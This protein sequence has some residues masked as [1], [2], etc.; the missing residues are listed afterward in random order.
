MRLAVVERVLR[1]DGL[2]AEHHAAVLMAQEMAVEHVAAGEL[3]EAV[4]DQGVAGCLRRAEG[5]GEGIHPH[6]RRRVDGAAVLEELERVGVDMERV[7]ERAAVGQLPLLGRTEQGGGIVAGVVELLA[8]DEVGVAR[9]GR[10][11]Q[12]SSTASSARRRTSG[13]TGVEA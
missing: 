13:L 7:L 8:I 9:F 6:P 3:L 4:A 10:P 12:G 11:A 1:A 2:S 5:N